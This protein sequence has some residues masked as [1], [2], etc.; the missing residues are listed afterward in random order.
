M[1]SYF[2]DEL[3]QKNGARTVRS[4]FCPELPDF[5]DRIYLGEYDCVEAAL[6]KALLYHT[7]VSECAGCCVK[8][9]A[10]Y[11]RIQIMLAS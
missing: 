9:P 3:S 6:N 10:G 7:N 8:N 4:A 2:L 11:S 5:Y 1:A